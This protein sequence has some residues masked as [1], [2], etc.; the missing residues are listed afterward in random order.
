MVLLWGAY[1]E[2]YNILGVYIEFPYSC[3]HHTGPSTLS[4]LFSWLPEG[5][6]H[7]LETHEITDG[8]GSMMLLCGESSVYVG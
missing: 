6:R 4:A 5:H 3:N 1:K 8:K 2:E 7:V